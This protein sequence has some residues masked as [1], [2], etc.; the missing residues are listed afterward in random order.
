MS[1]SANFI[2]TV[3]QRTHRTGLGFPSAKTQF[4]CIMV[5]QVSLITAKCSEAEFK[6]FSDHVKKITLDKGKQ[7]RKT[8]IKTSEMGG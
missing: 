2:F 8:L 1:I 3:V 5:M 7:V 4:S 6:L